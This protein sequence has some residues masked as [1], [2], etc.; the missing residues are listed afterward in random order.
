MI[1]PKKFLVVIYDCDSGVVCNRYATASG[2]ERHPHTVIGIFPVYT[3]GSHLSERIGTKGCSD[4]RNVRVIEFLTNSIMFANINNVHV[5]N[6][7][8][9][10]SVVIAQQNNHLIFSV[11]DSLL[12]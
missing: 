11:F 9:V 7:I 12:F 10:Y 6:T 3:V 5:F 4:N 2:Q 8:Y 1:S